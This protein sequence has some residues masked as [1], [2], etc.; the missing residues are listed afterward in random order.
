MKS[1]LNKIDPS[2]LAAGVMLR[3]KTLCRSRRE[4]AFGPDLKVGSSE[5]SFN[6]SPFCIR[7]K[8]G[9]VCM[10]IFAASDKSKVKEDR[11]Y[12]PDSVTAFELSSIYRL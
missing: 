4:T 12:P 8:K 6:G 2:M 1:L 9:A 5:T 3:A 10:M 11:L 7:G